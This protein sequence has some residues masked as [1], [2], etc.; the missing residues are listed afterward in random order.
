LEH[1]VRNG[2]G[3]LVSDESAPGMLSTPAEPGVPLAH[4]YEIPAVLVLH[5]V[6]AARHEVDGH[7][8]LRR[9]VRAWASHISGRGD[10]RLL[11]A[12]AA[13]SQALAE[14]SD[15][16]VDRLRAQETVTADINRVYGEELARLRA[17]VS[18]LSRRI[19]TAPDD[20]P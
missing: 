9:R 2:E 8:T 16:L 19:S 17:E 6:M 15:L 13:A 10:R 1:V 11:E 5:Q 12:L 18:H 20:A 4:A 14:H 7:Q 3:H